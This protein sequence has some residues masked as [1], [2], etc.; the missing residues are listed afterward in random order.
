MYK[1]ISFKTENSNKI[2]N[3]YNKLVEIQGNKSIP[4]LKI[5]AFDKY[6][7]N[8]KYYFFYIVKPLG[9]LPFEMI[10]ILM[11]IPIL[12]FFGLSK[13]LILPLLFYSFSFFVSSHFM[14]LLLLLSLRKVDLQRDV[15]RLYL[16][17]DFYE[18]YKVIS[19]N[20][21]KRNS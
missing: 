18:I 6:E 14:Y 19:G 7:Y 15:K 11:I 17:K 21:T 5:V 2:L 20:V 16:S 4:F 12:L 13:L 10:S 1:I 3:W 9:V 8:N